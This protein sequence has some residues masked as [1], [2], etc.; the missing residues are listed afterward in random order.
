[1]KK[2][3]KILTI[4]LWII[5]AGGLFTLLGFSYVEHNAKSCQKYTINIDY[6]NADIL[7]TNNDIYN[8]IRQ[9]G[10]ILK[11]QAIRY[12]NAEK[13]E[14]SIKKQPYVA[15]A[16]VYMTIDGN[17]EINVVQRQPI[18]R[19]FNQKGESFY[20]DGTGH[21]LPLN[22]DFS[23]RVLVANGN[24]PES[25]S[26]SV[27]YSEDSI[28]QKDSL[29]YRSVINNLYTLGMFIMKDHFLKALIEEIYVD[30]N[31]EFELIPKLGNQIILFGTAE[32][33]K[34]K[35][36][37]LLVFYKKG[38]SITGW[39]KYNVI[40]IKFRNQVICSKI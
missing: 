36:E 8:L 31:G 37:R 12:I 9:T 3:L 18:L 21:L 35:F 24:I 32:N 1:M 39:Q 25:L 17:V 38:L 40:N 16:N 10:H 13:I 26:K 6:G 5:L 11:G 30:K 34:D 2:F 4:A 14:S 27:N 19:I 28:R 15:N 20:L 7:V 23:A 29:L 33:V 22:P